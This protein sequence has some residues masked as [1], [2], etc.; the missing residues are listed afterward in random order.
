MKS[1]VTGS[2]WNDS[3]IPRFY[4]SVYDHL[5]VVF[6]IHCVL[7][8]IVSDSSLLSSKFDQLSRKLE[9]PFIGFSIRDHG[10]NLV[11]L[12]LYGEEVEDVRI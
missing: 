1:R 5:V 12:K 9:L 6:G 11:N 8:Q 4:V 7:L 2:D 10:I 3:T